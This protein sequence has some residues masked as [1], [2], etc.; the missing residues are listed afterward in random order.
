MK[1]IIHDLGEEI[2]CLLKKRM[3]IWLSFMRT[4]SMLTA[5]AASSAG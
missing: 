4:I 1:V 5:A 3:R 2:T